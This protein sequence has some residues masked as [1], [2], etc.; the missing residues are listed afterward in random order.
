MVCGVPLTAHAQFA[1]PR[2]SPG[3]PVAPTPPI[4]DKTDP[5]SMPGPSAHRH[6]KPHGQADHEQAGQS[7][8]GQP[9]AGQEP[10]MPPQ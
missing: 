7:P 3:K 10:A 8:S 6:R 5:D 4:H 9:S 1:A 2:S